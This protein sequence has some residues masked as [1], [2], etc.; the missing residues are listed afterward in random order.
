MAYFCMYAIPRVQTC[1]RSRTITH[2]EKYQEDNQQTWC[3]LYGLLL[4]FGCCCCWCLLLCLWMGC[5][6]LFV[7]HIQHYCFSQSRR[8]NG[9]N[10]GSLEPDMLVGFLQ[11]I[12]LC[13]VLKY[14]RTQDAVETSK[15][16]HRERLFP[17]LDLKYCQIIFV[18]I[19]SDNLIWRVWRCME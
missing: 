2:V 7:L 15:L 13:S 18:M 3:S 17:G 9:W 16:E 6:L 10:V 4:T 11:A 1:V 8:C 14:G 19:Y 12:F 5:G